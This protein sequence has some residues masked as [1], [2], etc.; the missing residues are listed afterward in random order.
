L[1][2]LC[3]V[4]F[5]DLIVNTR[6]DFL[7]SHSSGR[8][9][10]GTLFGSLPF[11]VVSDIKKKLYLE[12]ICDNAMIEAFGLA[13]DIMTCGPEAVKE[14]LTTLR[15]RQESVNDGLEVN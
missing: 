7:V 4:N 15:N 8:H 5:N 6:G 2:N 1:A 3:S 10:G 12:Q 13:S 14:C 9:F 11:L